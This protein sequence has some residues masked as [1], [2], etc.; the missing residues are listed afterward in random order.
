M[1]IKLTY[2]DGKGAAELTRLILAYGGQ[3]FTDERIKREDWPSLKE[4]TPLGMVP[5]LTLENG[6][7]EGFHQPQLKQKTLKL[8]RLTVD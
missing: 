1:S 6:K 3:E 7:Q 8:E 2:F 5:M 4:K